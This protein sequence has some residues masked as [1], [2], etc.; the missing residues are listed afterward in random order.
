MLIFGTTDVRY[1]RSH[2]ADNRYRCPILR[3]CCLQC[4]VLFTLRTAL[5]WR[6]NG[7]VRWTELDLCGMLRPCP[8]LW[9]SVCVLDYNVAIRSVNWVMR[10]NRSID[11]M[12]QPELSVIV[13]RAS[14]DHLTKCSTII[15]SPTVVKVCCVWPPVSALLMTLPRTGRLLTIRLLQLLPRDT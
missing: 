4:K 5:F 3:L 6:M 11:D 10:N 15:T 2:T 8:S 14:V 7:D 1:L 9:R 13:F 12:L